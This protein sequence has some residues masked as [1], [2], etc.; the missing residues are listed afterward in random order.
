MKCPRALLFSQEKR[1]VFLLAFEQQKTFSAYL[2]MSSHHFLV[3]KKQKYDH[4]DHWT[5]SF[6]NFMESASNCLSY[7]H[8]YP[9]QMLSILQK[10]LA[11]TWIV[12]SPVWWNRNWIPL[13]QAYERL[14][15]SMRLYTSLCQS[16]WF[17][18][19]LSV[20]LSV[21]LSY[22]LSVCLPNSMR[23]VSPVSGFVL[24]WI[25]S[26]FLY[27]QRHLVF[28]SWTSCGWETVCQPMDSHSTEINMMCDVVD[29]MRATMIVK[30]VTLCYRSKSP[31]WSDCHWAI[32]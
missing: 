18:V 12:W 28:E 11:V 10:W 21:R 25:P 13:D 15:A 32:P 27:H 31:M 17:S 20:C 16:V 7:L 4:L 19:C 9:C 5:T 26:C 14:V 24:K 2:L 3:Q 1:N 23:Q 6:F 30:N 22:C 29:D 8:L